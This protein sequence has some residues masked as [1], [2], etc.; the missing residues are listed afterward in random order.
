MAADITLFKEQFK[1][2]FS[3]KH[4][5]LNNIEFNV[6]DSLYVHKFDIPDLARVWSRDQLFEDAA[7]SGDCSATFG[8]VVLKVFVFLFKK[9][10]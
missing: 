2:T 5:Y 10:I 1:Y 7:H 9:N 8:T 4:K 6:L 3:K